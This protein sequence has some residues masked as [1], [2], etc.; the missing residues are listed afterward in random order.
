[1]IPDNWYK[2]PYGKRHKFS[3][4]WLNAK[5]KE[6]NMRTVGM[7]DGVFDLL[8]TGHIKHLTNCRKLCDYLV[9]A[10]AD[11]KFVRNKKGKDRPIIGEDDR[12][13]AL[14]ALRVVD[15]AFIC[16]G[17][18]ASINRVRPHAYFKNYDYVLNKELHPD[19]LVVRMPVYGSTTKLIEKIRSGK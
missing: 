12:L 7:C 8:H 4:R 19:I 1:M 6:N 18:V 15:E 14:R 9:V 10:V 11:D 13:L 3:H 5:P 2:E 17:T 16:D